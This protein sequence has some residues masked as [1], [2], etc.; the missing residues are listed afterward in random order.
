MQNT[1]HIFLL[2]ALLLSVFNTEAFNPPDSLKSKY[3][4]NDPRNP[5]CPC[6]KYQKLAE[7]EYQ[8]LK[9]ATSNP[10]KNFNS[11]SD[12]N[13]ENTSLNSKEKNKTTVARKY[14]KQHK[15]YALTS[16][17]KVKRKRI[18]YNRKD[19]SRCFRWN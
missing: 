1:K 17:H 11:N 6:H 4:L 3:A 16:K 10:N 9:K 5:N 18:K 14:Y 15:I 13:T 7:E 2:F 19:S 12:T 8:K